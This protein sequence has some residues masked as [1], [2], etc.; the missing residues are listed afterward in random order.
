MQD[1]EPTISTM[2]ISEL[3]N[4]LT[5]RRYIFNK[6]HVNKIFRK[7]NRAEYIALYLIRETEEKQEDYSSRT[8]L[9]ELSEKMQ[10][11][12]RQ[13]SRIVRTMKEN[14]LLVWTHDGDGSEGT[15][16]TITEQGKKLLAEEELNINAYYGKVIAKFGKDNLVLLLQLMKQLETV[17]SSEMED[18]ED[19]VDD[20]N[21]G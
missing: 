2:G 7:L 4:E 14:G 19:D 16:V 6:E 1:K 18:M 21:D 10:L 13:I 20:D 9:K 5:Y 12:I 8:Y 15:Y 17:M 3:S 11:P